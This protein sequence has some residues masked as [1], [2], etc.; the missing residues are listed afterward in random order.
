MLRSGHF[1]AVDLDIGE[2]SDFLRGFACQV[3][4]TLFSTS[5]TYALFCSFGQLFNDSVHGSRFP[6]SWYAGDV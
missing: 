6:S 1:Q 5:R 3:A 4:D 2:W